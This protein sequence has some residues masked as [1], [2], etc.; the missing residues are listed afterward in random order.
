M[1]Y[2]SEE[3]DGCDLAFDSLGASIILIR[4]RLFNDLDKVINKKYPEQTVGT[5]LRCL[6]LIGEEFP[7]ELSTSFKE[8]HLAEVKCKFLSWYDL[9]KEKIPKNYREGVYK[10]TMA[11]I[12]LFEAYFNGKR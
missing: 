10:N 7:K 12:E 5:T 1:S 9:V 8:K 6:R 11:E 3:L 4:K 2:W